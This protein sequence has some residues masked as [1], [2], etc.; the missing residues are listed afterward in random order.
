MTYISRSVLSARDKDK[1]TKWARPY[2]CDVQFNG[3][4]IKNICVQFQEPKAKKKH[5]RFFLVWMGG[6]RKV[7]RELREEKKETNG[8]EEELYFTQETILTF[9]LGE[10]SGTK[11]FKPSGQDQGK[12]QPQVSSH[13]DRKKVPLCFLQGECRLHR[14][15][16][17]RFSKDINMGQ[18]T[19]NHTCSLPFFL[20][21]GIYTHT[22]THH[23]H[24]C[25]NINV[26]ICLHLVGLCYIYT[27]YTHANCECVCM[28]VCPASVSTGDLLKNLHINQ[29]L[30]M[31]KFLI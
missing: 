6:N 28:C 1:R 18:I 8:Q 22:H 23:I 2:F 13:P 12:N 25:L 15:R 30:R 29:H 19:E 10:L 20:S 21:E 16:T 11:E 27:V 14:M 4:C 26:D 24:I 7:Q 17:V 9:G 5:K 31:V 3:T